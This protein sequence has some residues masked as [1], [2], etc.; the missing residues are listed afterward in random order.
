M[1]KYGTLL[2]KGNKRDPVRLEKGDENMVDTCIVCGM[3]VPEGRQVCPACSGELKVKEKERDED[4]SLIVM[5]RMSLDK[6]PCTG[7]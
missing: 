7:R 2:P 4:Y 5:L 6:I 1:P 3:D